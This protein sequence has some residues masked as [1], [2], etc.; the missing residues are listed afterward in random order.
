MQ[1]GLASGQIPASG[2][3]KAAL[4]R[5]WWGHLT[6]T[7]R[8][9]GVLRVKVADGCITATCVFED[10]TVG[11]SI[12]HFRGGLNDRSAR[13]QLMRFACPGSF[14][15]L[16]GEITFE[17]S[18]DST[19]AR[20]TWRTD[21]GTAGVCTFSKTSRWHARWLPR[22]CW[23]KLRI[24][25]FRKAPALYCLLLLGVAI[26]SL[27]GKC[28]LGWQALVLLLLPALLLFQNRLEGIVRGLRI[29]KAG[30]LEFAEQP[31]PVDLPALIGH[32]DQRLR[33][34]ALD[35]TF[36]PRTKLLLSWLAGRTSVPRREFETIANS[37]GVDGDNLAATIAVLITSGCALFQD[38]QLVISE[39]GRHYVAYL[40]PHS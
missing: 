36:V 28:Q 23:A 31:T 5:F 24:L 19:S 34:S 21:I 17:L 30:P 29:R 8:A 4:S 3:N 33:F 37:I 15:P 10:Q 38:D 2:K 35:M 18:A 6:G 25:Y 7:N 39:R 40:A 12:A 11:P 13:L 26:A 20:G 9:L 14:V 32:L 16:D 27:L 22:I 1:T